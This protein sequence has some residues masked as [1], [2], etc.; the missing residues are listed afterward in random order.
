VTT[1]PS[2]N[3]G[4]DPNTV[5]NERYI[6]TYTSAVWL[7]R[8]WEE[9]HKLLP[10]IYDKCMM[11]ESDIAAVVQECSNY[12]QVTCPLNAEARE[13]M[14]RQRLKRWAATAMA[15]MHHVG[16]FETYVGVIDESVEGP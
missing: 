7:P 10:H 16:E 3:K 8:E 6:V 5:Q 13:Q 11:D 14:Y 4:T 2:Q 15:E 9:F 1:D 12:A